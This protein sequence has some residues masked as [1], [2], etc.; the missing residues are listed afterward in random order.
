MAIRAL[1]N[2]QW[3]F[4]SNCFVCEPTNAAGLRIPFEHDD[5]AGVVRAT[6]DLDGRFSGAPSYV[7][8]GVTLAVLD[9]AMAWATIAI[10]GK[11]AVTSETTT[12]FG[13]GVR[14]G[15]TYTVEA[16]VDSADADT[17]QTSARVLDERG[18]P[19]VTATATFTVLGAAQVVDVIGV[20]D[21]GADASYVKD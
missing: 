18:R 13:Y 17:M 10:G 11:F 7:H 5:E 20:D 21:L 9:E 4:T 14:I 6:F 12:K 15:R 2:E 3:G 1:S 16:T 8:G 19:C